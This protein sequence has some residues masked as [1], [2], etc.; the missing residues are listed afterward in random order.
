MNALVAKQGSDWQ[1]G[2]N[3]M[4]AGIP[5]LLILLVG[6]YIVFEMI[7][8]IGTRKSRPKPPEN[9]PHNKPDETENLSPEKGELTEQEGTPP[10]WENRTVR[11]IKMPKSKHSK[12]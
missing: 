5:F 6:F 7:E 10:G 12:K 2:R 11:G 8:K 1:K 9:P 3:K 4:M